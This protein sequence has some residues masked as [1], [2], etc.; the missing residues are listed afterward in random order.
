VDLTLGKPY[1]EVMNHARQ[2]YTQ[3]LNDELTSG[4]KEFI[5]NTW[6]H[7][8]V[9][10]KAEVLEVKS[11]SDL[12]KDLGIEKL[13]DGTYTKLGRT[14]ATGQHCARNAQGALLS[15]YS[16]ALKEHQLAMQ[17]AGEL[18][19]SISG[20][21]FDQV[22][23][24][25]ILS[26]LLCGAAGKE[27]TLAQVVKSRHMCP[28]RKRMEMTVHPISRFAMWTN[29]IASSKDKSKNLREKTSFM[30][31]CDQNPVSLVTS[32]ASMHMRN[33]N[34]AVFSGE[35]GTFMLDLYDNAY[36]LR[37]VTREFDQYGLRF[38]LGGDDGWISLGECPIEDMQ[39]VMEAYEKTTGVKW[40]DYGERSVLCIEAVDLDKFLNMEMIKDI[41]GREVDALTAH[42]SQ[43][44]CTIYG[45]V[46]CLVWEGESLELAFPIYNI[47]KI[48]DSWWQ[49]SNKP[50]GTSEDEQA[51]IRAIGINMVIG[52]FKP[53]NQVLTEWVEKHPFKEGTPITHEEWMEEVWPKGVK[54]TEVE[55]YDEVLAHWTRK[56]EKYDPVFD[57]W[58]D[59]ASL[60]MEMA[61]GDADE[62]LRVEKA[63]KLEGQAQEG[64]DKRT[65]KAAETMIEWD[66]ALI[67][68]FDEHWVHDG[69][70]DK[71]VLTHYHSEN[72]SKLFGGLSGPAIMKRAVARS[73]IGLYAGGAFIVM[74]RDDDFWVAETTKGTVLSFPADAWHRRGKPVVTIMG[75]N[76]CVLN[77]PDIKLE[78]EYCQQ[79]ES[80][81]MGKTTQ[82]SRPHPKSERFK[83]SAKKIS[84]KQKIQMSRKQ[85][86]SKGK[87]VLYDDDYR[88]IL[89]SNSHFEENL[90]DD[91]DDWDY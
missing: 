50:R 45:M 64:V 25:H 51:S 91:E 69:Q 41:S 29:V 80:Q 63:R 32:K 56:L 58:E 43:R 27:L 10:V 24:K 90:T 60:T 46:P 76:F 66:M 47:S 78:V 42:S 26:Y 1:G 75:D 33:S 57:N 71:E 19:P 88:I 14:F 8:L 72:W 31:N 44:Y 73:Q 68:Y 34:M 38:V 7:R 17:R 84:R 37:T 89:N 65:D 85:A 12:K 36:D 83:K 61:W 81:G 13:K 30:L 39:Q 35:S 59:L 18:A 62:E 82:Q 40:T 86:R 16:E 20:I 54:V 22:G 70:M 5:E 52:M 28:D 87:G 15:G 9:K 48:I 77:H 6:N 53:I 23:I 49:P 3:W 21:T 11:A 74:K 4:D 79:E 67:K 55:A 2:E